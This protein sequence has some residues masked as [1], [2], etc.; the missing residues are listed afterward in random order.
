M[1]LRGKTQSSSLESGTVEQEEEVKTEKRGNS[2]SREALTK[3]RKKWKKI[4]L[5]CFVKTK[6]SQLLVRLSSVGRLVQEKRK[7]RG[8]HTG[9][10]NVRAGY[11][12]FKGQ[13]TS[14][15]SSA[16]VFK[17]LPPAT[18]LNFSSVNRTRAATER[19]RIFLSQAVVEKENEVEVVKILFIFHKIFHTTTML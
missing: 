5:F 11:R 2:T 3:K 6:F 16:K 9:R 18:A 19:R 17:K 15:S 12:R 7:C 14:T 13:K 8:R 10:V 4:F 1:W